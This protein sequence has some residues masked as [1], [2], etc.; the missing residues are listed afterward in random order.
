MF[1]IPLAIW[2][3]IISFII[4]TFYSKFEEKRKIK[5]KLKH[6]ESY[7]LFWVD[8]L[9]NHTKKFI[10]NLT[11]FN[12]NLKTWDENIGTIKYIQT[13]LP[14][15]KFE[16]VSPVEM[17]AT[18]TFNK[19]GDNKLNNNQYLILINT[20]DYLNIIS[21]EINNKLEEFR[22]TNNDYRKKISETIREINENRI[23]FYQARNNP[24]DDEFLNAFL[25]LHEKNKESCRTNMNEC[26]KN[27]IIPLDKICTKA[28][29]KYHTD[30][31]ITLVQRQVQ[32]FKYYHKSNEGL[33]SKLF[34][35]LSQVIFR[36]EISK[37]NLTSFNEY[38]LNSKFKSLFQLQ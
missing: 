18:F 19:A 21:T 32:L 5:S 37:D 14:L 1:Y 23:Q 26:L 6:N 25:L 8:V 22:R 24:T 38:C 7:I 3:I 27:Y 20:L 10:H 16:N 28:F 36:L 2:S 4:V 30:N 9:T 31:R 15:Q 33:K 35:Y 13:Q 11:I 29:Q 12:D 34:E 17:Y